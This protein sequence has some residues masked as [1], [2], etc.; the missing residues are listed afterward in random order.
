MVRWP[1]LIAAIAVLATIGALIAAC[2]RS[3]E[4]SIQSFCRDIASAEGLDESLA[5]LDPETLAPDVAALRKAARV[6]PPEV[7]PQVETLV[8]LT[9]VL[10][11][12]IETARTDQAAALEQTLREHAADVASVTLAGREVETYTR[13]NCGLELNTTAVP[14]A[15]PTAPVE[16]G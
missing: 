1:L 15:P 13:D 4:R 14:Q 8:S 2:E 9:T 6:A 7:S 16:G 12:T 10:Q 5:T 3:P 11:R